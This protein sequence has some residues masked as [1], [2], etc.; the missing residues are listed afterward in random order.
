MNYRVYYILFIILI[1]LILF[2]LLNYFLQ[3]TIE[4]YGV[5]CGRYN[6]DKET[7]EK[8]CRADAECKWN[9]YVEPTKE[10]MKWC[11]IDDIK[12][13]RKKD[14]ETSFWTDIQDVY[15]VA[16]KYMDKIYYP[17]D[18]EEIPESNVNYS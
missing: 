6:L 11:S 3:K 17:P 15:N 12:N 4:N 5:A 18:S 10:V 14:E 1:I 13:I 7:A 9:T 16:S 2:I 8:L